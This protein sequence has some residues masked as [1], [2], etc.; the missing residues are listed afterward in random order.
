[1]AAGLCGEFPLKVLQGLRTKAEGELV[2]PFQFG[3]RVG[4]AKPLLPRYL[5][6]NKNQGPIA[7]LGGV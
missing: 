2:V 6:L 1:M 5:I 4:E 7:V 3:K